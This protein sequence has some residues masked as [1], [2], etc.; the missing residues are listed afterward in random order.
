MILWVILTVLII[1]M[2]LL[3]YSYICLVKKSN[4]I[5]ENIESDIIKKFDIC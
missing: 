2:I 4:K 5:L 1:I 3:I